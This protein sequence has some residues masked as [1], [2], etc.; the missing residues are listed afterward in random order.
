MSAQSHYRNQQKYHRFWGGAL[1][2]CAIGLSACQTSQSSAI[3]S[4]STYKEV[5]PLSDGLSSNYLM[6][7]HAV[8][9]ND[10]QSATSFF[11]KSLL[12][13]DD[14]PALL[15]HSFLTQYQSGN[16]AEAAKI[17]RRMEALNLMLPLA[18]EPAL[19]EAVLSEDWD[20]V[21]ALADLLAQSDTSVILAGVTKSW[22][23]L[24]QGQF[25][26][27]ITQMGQTASLLENELGLT[28]AFMELQKVHLLEVGGARDEALAL[29]KD[30]RSLNS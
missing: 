7:R 13:D 10:L 6:A 29:L 28:P 27:A 19:I 12:Y 14:N 15:R 26:A 4:S 11:T 20:A 16:I 5:T 21:I 17:A 23:L 1:L 9:A 22:A 30:L 2:L 18:S 25:S 8:Y 24:A 3:K